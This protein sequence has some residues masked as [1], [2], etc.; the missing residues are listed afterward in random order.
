MPQE[1]GSGIDEAA[2]RGLAKDL[3]FFFL[4]FLAA[5]LVIYAI[6]LKAGFLYMHI[7][8]WGASPLL[9]LFGEKMIFER[10]L[11]VTEE[12]SLNPAVFLSLV[13]AVS[14]VPWKKRIRPAIIG[15]CVLTLANILTVFL[16]FMSAYLR[17]EK[18]WEGTEF[19][20]LT[21]NFFMPILLWFLLMPVRDIFPLRRG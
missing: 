18:L 12:I 13:I 17:N 6:Y 20:S 1:A 15:V 4:R 9:S 21:I 14:N 5:S 3:A 8:A 10:A 11:K 19:F 2:A 16:I 7:V